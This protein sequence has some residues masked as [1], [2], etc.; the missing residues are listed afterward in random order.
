MLITNLTFC[1]GRAVDVYVNQSIFFV[2]LNA[3]NFIVS[4][5]LEAVEANGN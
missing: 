3:D 4:M 1:D 5:L 2:E